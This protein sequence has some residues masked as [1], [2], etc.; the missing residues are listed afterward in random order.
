MAEAHFIFTC[1]LQTARP[2]RFELQSSHTE[3]QPH[4][5]QPGVAENLKF[6]NPGWADPGGRISGFPIFRFPWTPL[7]AGFSAV[8]VNSSGYRPI[9]WTNLLTEKGRTG[10][11]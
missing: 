2:C 6:C 8:A 10:R 7:P 5:L 1:S 9:A 3:W 11:L 4:R